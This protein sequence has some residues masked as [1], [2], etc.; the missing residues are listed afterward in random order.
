MLHITTATASL[1]AA[2]PSKRQY[3]WV[4]ESLDSQLLRA[5]FDVECPTCRYPIWVT[6]AEVIAQASVT[7]PCCRNRTWLRDEG[8]S[9]QNAGRAIEQRINDTLKDLWR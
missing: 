8:G 9:F 5:D 7:C 3:V 1:H 4:A 2:P 6:G